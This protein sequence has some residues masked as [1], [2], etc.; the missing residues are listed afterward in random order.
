LQ[1]LERR[2]HFEELGV[3]RTITLLLLLFKCFSDL[4]SLSL[5][6]LLSLPSYRSPI[7]GLTT[8]GTCVHT[9]TQGDFLGKLHK[10]FFFN[11]FVLSL[12]NNFY[13]NIK[14]IINNDDARFLNP[15]LLLKIPNGTRKNFSENY[16]H[17]SRRSQKGSPALPHSL[18]LPSFIH[19]LVFHFA[20]FQV[21][22]AAGKN[23]TA[24]Q[25]IGPYSLAELDRRF[26]GYLLVV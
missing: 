18:F 15:I 16:R 19:L 22:A 7:P 4:P 13:N 11:Y 23:T 17:L 14:T 20:I 2:N 8:Y 24:F 1:Y 12:C 10:N 5:P 6:S 21:L 26:R 25:D 3:D 9:G